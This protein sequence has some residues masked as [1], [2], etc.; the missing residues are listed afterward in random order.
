LK[1]AEPWSSQAV[2]RAT[3]PREQPANPLNRQPN[4]IARQTRQTK[5][6]AMKSVKLMLSTTHKHI[7][8]I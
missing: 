4:Q 6:D 1:I 5:N 7:N 8:E 2:R 3:A